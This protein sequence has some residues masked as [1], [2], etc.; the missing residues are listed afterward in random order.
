MG[1]KPVG[2]NTTV[3][4]NNGLNAT[5]KIPA[6]MVFFTSLMYHNKKFDFV[7]IQFTVNNLLNTLYY[8]PGPRTANGNST[9]SYNGFVPWVPQQTRNYLLTLNFKL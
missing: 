8:S 9:D 7:T 6:Y 4:L 3:P 1:S 5:D 2:P